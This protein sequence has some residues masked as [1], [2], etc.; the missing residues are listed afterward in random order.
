MSEKFFISGSIGIDEVGKGA[1]A[2]PV[3]ASALWFNKHITL[4]IL[5]DIGVNDSKKLSIKKREIINKIL[6]EMVDNK[7]L[8]Y[9][10]GIVEP[11][12]ID[13]IGISAST[14]KAMKIAL[15]TVD[16]KSD[17]VLI[18]GKINPFDFPV[19][20]IVKGD[21]KCY[22]IGAASIIAKIFR[23]KTMDELA[24]DDEFACYNWKRNK[25][26]GSAEHVSAIKKY[27]VSSHHRKSFCKNF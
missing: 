21:E 7:L 15:D 4:E 8:Y 12:E 19:K 13:R 27:G 22:N 1:I 14:N 11:D 25:G 23:D 17:I 24:E 18:D 3:V 5:S 20:T 2:G 9:G 16:I 6:M 26:Y 10:L